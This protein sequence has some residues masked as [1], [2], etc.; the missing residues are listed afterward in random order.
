MVIE[1]DQLRPVL[2][3]SSLVLLIL[4]LVVALWGIILPKG[5]L[6][7]VARAL[8]W[9]T[10]SVCALFWCAVN[11]ALW[12]VSGRPGWLSVLLLVQALPTA[13]AAVV[14]GWV[15]ILQRFPGD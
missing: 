3:A 7:N 5:F 2:Q 12:R 11:F 6:S 9:L 4:M 1:P 10:L 14:V 8:G 15:L 13:C